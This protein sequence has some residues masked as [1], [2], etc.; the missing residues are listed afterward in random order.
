MRTPSI[1]LAALAAAVAAC[2]FIHL[3]PI[4]R[5]AD[6][7]NTDKK[8]VN[9]AA[10]GGLAE[11][12]LGEYASTHGSN[13]A[14]KT[15]G[16]QMVS[17][18]SSA[19]KQLQDLCSQEG[20]DCPSSPDATDSAEVDELTKLNGAPFDRAYATAMVNDHDQTIALFKKEVDDGR[21]PGL[22]KFASDTLPTLEHHLEMAQAMSTQVAG[23]K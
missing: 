15:F 19:N 8:F 12:K 17:D 16:Q 9:D 2:S 23:E 5:A 14:V 3:S 20:I 11:V 4:A 21:D 22:R 7:S 6:L 1:R 13:G 18:H 10:S